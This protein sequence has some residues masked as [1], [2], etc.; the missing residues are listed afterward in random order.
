[1]TPIVEVNVPTTS[2]QPKRAVNGCL[3][4]SGPG[5][6]VL[7]HRGNGLTV[8]P[9]RVPK[10]IVHQYFAKWLEVSEDGGKETLLIPVGPVDAGIADQLSSFA[11][12]VRALK[13][14]WSSSS[15]N[16]HLLTQSQGWRQEIRFPKKIERVMAARRSSRE[17]RHGPIQA[18]LR[19]VLLGL[20]A[21]KYHV[22]LNQRVDLGVLRDSRL[23]AVFEVKTDLGDQ[24]YAG[25][26]QPTY[27]ITGSTV[28]CSTPM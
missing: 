17:Y 7:C 28:V 24:L 1:M 18:A 2:G 9:R 26:G 21:S 11:D 19:K 5:R 8:A 13:E 15:G 20:L 10:E 14:S 23:F 25:I 22:V 3:C 12:A 27:L 16:P 4:V 6:F